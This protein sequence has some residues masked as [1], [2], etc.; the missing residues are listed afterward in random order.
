MVEE[1]PA[2]ELFELDESEYSSKSEYSKPS[3]IQTQ[4]MRCNELRSKE[5]SEGH[6]FRTM[7]KSGNYKVI[8]LPDTR[9]PYVGAVI[10]LKNNLTPEILRDNEIKTELEK[11]KD[12]MDEL[13]NKYKYEELKLSYNENKEP[14]LVYTNDEYLPKKGA[15]LIKRIVRGG[16]KPPREEEVEGLWDNKINAYWDKMVF[17]YDE[18]FSVLNILIDKNE[19]FKPVSGW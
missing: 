12:K 11:I 19:Y 13:F 3:V 14:I 2:E 16:N 1:N 5:M 8:D 4:V 18:L 9:Q 15:I 10:A 6:T 7:D 17:V